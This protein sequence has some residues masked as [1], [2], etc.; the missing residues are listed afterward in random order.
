MFMTGFM[1][2]AGVGLLLAKLK[3]RTMLKVLKHD[4]MLDLAV[5]A[6]VLA[7]HWGT[8]SGVMTAMVVF[9]LIKEI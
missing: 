1:I 4:L 5:T 8:F 2:F 7:I 3:R 9:N 6:A